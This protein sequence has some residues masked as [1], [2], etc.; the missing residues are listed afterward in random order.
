M[1]K[2]LIAAFVFVVLI[3][4]FAGATTA[5]A[6]QPTQQ[7]LFLGLSSL[8]DARLAEASDDLQLLAHTVGVTN[9][10]KGAIPDGDV[11]KIIR[12]AIRFVACVYKHNGITHVTV[13]GKQISLTDTITA[14]LAT[15]PEQ[16]K[17]TS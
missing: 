6:V 2:S 14:L 10:T 7:E 5:V 9:Y 16:P 15:V 1:R 13:A 8:Y 11:V 4:G 3:V 17:K 12:E